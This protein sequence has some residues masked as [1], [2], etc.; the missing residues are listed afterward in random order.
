MQVQEEDKDKEDVIAYIRFTD[1]HGSSGLRAV[2]SKPEGMPFPAPKRLA[3]SNG[4]SSHRGQRGAVALSPLS[5]L[6]ALFVP[7]PKPAPDT[8]TSFTSQRQEPF[9]SLF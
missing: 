6:A 3:T 7:P 4:S 2:C 5:A 1:T 8:C 9:D